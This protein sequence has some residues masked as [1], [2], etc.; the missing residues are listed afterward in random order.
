MQFHDLAETLLG[1]KV[2]I[3]VLRTLWKYKEKEFTIR[4]LAKFLGI[5]HTGIKKVLDELE[6]TNVVK[7]RTLGKSHAFRL[8]AGSYTA[9][10]VEDVFEKEGK[11]LS[12]LQEMLKK[13]LVS[14][15]VTSAALF[16]SVAKVKETPLSDID[17]FVVTENREKV[18]EIIAELQ[19]HV[20]EKFGN[21]ISAYYVSKED[22]KKK[23][24]D[25]PIK[26]VLQ[27]HLLICGKPLR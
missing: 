15:W 20:S 23:R 17:L 21:S 5:S 4:E 9:R 24:R 8:N 25:S 14:P 10:I 6:K 1:S 13:G 27:D 12:E 11:A 3:K 2:K 16:G 18:E 7:L 26:Q 22:L 19:K